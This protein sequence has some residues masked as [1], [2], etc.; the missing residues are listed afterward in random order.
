MRRPIECVRSLLGFYVYSGQ[1]DEEDQ[2]LEAI[3]DVVA[4]VPIFFRGIYRRKLE[5]AT[6]IPTTIAVACD[7]RSLTVCVHKPFT[8]PLDGRRVRVE[9]VTGHDMDLH[10]EIEEGSVSQV[11]TAHGKGQINRFFRDETSLYLYVRIFA[12]QLPAEVEYLLTY[13]ELPSV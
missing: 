8:A 6:R 11:F 13:D 3:D 4:H 2:R 7:A 1:P 12:E 5:Q 9:T 10:F